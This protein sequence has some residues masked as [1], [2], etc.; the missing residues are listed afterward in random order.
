MSPSRLVAPPRGEGGISQA[1]VE[2]C[3]HRPGDLV[4]AAAWESL[5]VESIE[6]AD[7]RPLKAPGQSSAG[8]RK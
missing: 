4:T 1:I 5:G 6:R 2:D 7:V 8:S 3:S